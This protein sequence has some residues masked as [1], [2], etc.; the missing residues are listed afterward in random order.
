MRRY[1]SGLLLAV[2]IGLLLLFTAAYA[3]RYVHPKH[4][5]WL[6]VLAVGLPVLSMFVVVASAV[7][8][9]FRRHPALLLAHLLAVVLVVV[10]FFP[11]ER[12]LRS[13]AG[14]RPVLR[15]LTNNVKLREGRRGE[16]SLLKA[17]QEAHP[18][19]IG[20]QETYTGYSAD[21]PIMIMSPQARLVAEAGW[22]PARWM[23]DPTEDG[24]RLPVFSKLDWVEP[25]LRSWS[26]DSSGE[27]RQVLTRAVLRWE[28]QAVAIYNVHL[29]SFNPDGHSSALTGEIGRLST[30][31]ANMLSYGKDFLIRADEASQIRE[32][33]SQEE[34]PYIICGDFNSTP[35]QWVYWHLRRGHQDVFEV[36]GSGWGGTYHSVVPLVRIDHMLVSPHWRIL[37][38]RILRSTASD[39]RPLVAKIS[40]P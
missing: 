38:A 25:G 21:P 14:D 12:L 40:L 1:V 39:H 15:V 10:R 4:G 8:L 37:D 6:Q 28:G 20:L 30:L 36:A 33:L 35:H 16:A 34:L 18:D 19:I 7:V 29:R 32:I 31:F 26:I 23:S 5:W 3:A 22:E 17:F 27:R 13:S 11:T 24:T 2:D 9:A